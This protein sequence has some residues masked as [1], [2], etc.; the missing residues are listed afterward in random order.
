MYLLFTPNI[1]HMWLTLRHTQYT[2]CLSKEYVGGRQLK[3]CMDYHHP[4][5]K[6]TLQC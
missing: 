5:E 6:E 1:S 4:H 2:F 3:M